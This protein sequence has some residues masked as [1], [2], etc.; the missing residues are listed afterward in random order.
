MHRAGGGE[1]RMRGIEKLGAHEKVRVAAL[2][3]CDQY[4]AGRSNIADCM[5]RAI[6]IAPTGENAAVWGS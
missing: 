3:T 4:L 1:S 2:T 6:V 5:V